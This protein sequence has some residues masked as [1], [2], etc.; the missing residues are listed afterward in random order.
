M[1]SSDTQMLPFAQMERQQPITPYINFDANELTETYS[2]EE[3]T[4]VSRQLT[5]IS[6]EFKEEVNF[7]YPYRKSQ[8]TISTS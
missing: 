2:R 8:N 3:L 6:Q 7:D 4:S 1:K 5:S